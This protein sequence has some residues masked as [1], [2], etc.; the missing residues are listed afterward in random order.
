MQQHIS[1][2]VD[3]KIQTLI[4]EEENPKVKASELLKTGELSVES[5]PA[6]C[7]MIHRCKHRYNITLCLYCK[8]GVSVKK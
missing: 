6:E 8:S 3:M 4:L 2:A 1:A 7:H 5:L